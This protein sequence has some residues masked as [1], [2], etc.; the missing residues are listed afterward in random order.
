[1]E[2]FAGGPADDIIGRAIPESDPNTKES[3]FLDREHIKGILKSSE[4]FSAFPG[5]VLDIL[6]EA[7]DSIGIGAGEPLF[8]KGDEG[9]CMYAITRGQV[10]VHDGNVTLKLM[11]PGDVLGE[12]AVLD[13]DV[14]SASATAEADTHL[15]RLRKTDLFNLIENHGELTRAILH[16]LSQRVRA[17]SSSWVESDRNRVALEHELEIGRKIQSSFLPGDLPRSPGWEMAGFFRSARQVAGDF[18]DMF[19]LPGN[20]KVALVIGDVCDKGVGAALFMTLFRSLFRSNMQTIEEESS[21]DSDI[22]VNSVSR[23]NHYIATTHG[24]TSMYATM[25]A[26]VLDPGTGRLHYVSAGHESPYIIDEAGETRSLETTGP[27]V[28]LFPEAIFSSRQTVLQP[29]ETLFAYT[30]GVVDAKSPDGNTFDLD[31]LLPLFKG[32]HGAADLLEKIYRHL[33]AFID[34]ANQFD[35]IT[36]FAVKREKSR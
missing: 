7:M 14:R 2:P 30:D 29:G 23:T 26:A 5:P 10:R 15:C 17:T 11:G 13:P 1:M 22:L 24:H 33:A 3:S 31:R 27:A 35:D 32:D 18:Y 4:F 34:E 19:E 9:D 8:A 28:G 36:M 25:F 12:M 20:A 21:V 6:V 16:V